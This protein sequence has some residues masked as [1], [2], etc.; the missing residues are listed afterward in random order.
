MR[1]DGYACVV[2]GG[3]HH[4]LLKQSFWSQDA[5]CAYITVLCTSISTA[6]YM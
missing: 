4:C 3:S 6:L 5:R 1:I 2:L